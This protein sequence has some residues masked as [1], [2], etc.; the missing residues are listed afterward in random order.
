MKKLELTKEAKPENLPLFLGFVDLICGNAGVE[1]S[2]CG[3]VKLAVEEACSN[4][5]THGYAG[6]TRGDI[7]LSGHREEDR[8]VVVISD[9][10]A[11]FGPDDA[12]PPDLTADWRERQIGGLGWHLIRKVVDDVS[13]DKAGDVNQLTLTIRVK[14]V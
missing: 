9:Q 4:I 8:L 3:D 5:I 10:G 11:P 1:A 14:E 2:Q 7:R 12:P 13:Y 6:R